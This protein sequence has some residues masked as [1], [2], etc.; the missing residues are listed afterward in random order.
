MNPYLEQDD[1]RRDFHKTFLVRLAV[2]VR[3][4]LADDYIL[5]IEEHLYVHERPVEPC[6]LTTKGNAP[7]EVP[8]P[9]ILPLVDVE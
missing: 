1:I 5:K 3:A 6:I 9:V 8:V 2:T 7:A 4:Q